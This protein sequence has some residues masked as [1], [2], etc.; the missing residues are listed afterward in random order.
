VGSTTKEIK[1]MRQLQHENTLSYYNCYKKGQEIW[2]V[3]EYCECGSVQGIMEHFGR[4]LE[5]KYISPITYQV[6]CGLRYLHG[7]E[8]IHRDI[9]A[10]N[11]LITADCIV[12]IADFGTS[13]D[14]TIRTT[15]IGSSYW[16]APETLNQQLYDAKADIWSLGITLI[17]IAEK[18]PPYSHLEPHEVV[19]EVVHLAAPNLKQ[20]S[21]WSLNFREF[22]KYC[23][24]KDPIK[25][26]DAETLFRHPFVST[27]DPH[28]MEW[29]L[30]LN[31]LVSDLA[32]RRGLKREQTAYRESRENT[33]LIN[34]AFT[35]MDINDTI[36]NTPP[37]NTGGGNKD[38]SEGFT[39][40]PKKKT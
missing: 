33:V 1:F 40:Q 26:L 16:M 28:K 24:Q 36:T 19:R 34:D 38:Q 25:R 2:I 27:L 30:N 9:K 35:K 10:A 17:E 21:K 12:K 39:Y 11:L 5:E 8:K 32:N 15:I 18:N 3:M 23:L 6:L 4:G 31:D 20:P 7:K 29:K 22:V 13:A 37:P 14:G